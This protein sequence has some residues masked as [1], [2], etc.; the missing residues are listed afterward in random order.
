MVGSDGEEWTKVSVISEERLKFEIAKAEWEA[1]ESSSSESDGEDENPAETTRSDRRISAREDDLN[2][3][4]LVRFADALQRAAKA[5]RTR[6]KHPQVRIVLPRV[7]LNP[8]VELHSLLARIRSTGAVVVL[9]PQ[10]V[11]ST[12]LNKD[13][14][15]KLLPAP[16]PPLT[17]TLNLDCSILLA[18]AS[19]LSHAANHPILPEYKVFIKQQ[20][21]FETKEPS[22]P[23][24]LW[25]AM[26]GRNLICT[27]EAANT[28]KEIVDALGTST[29]RKRT[30]LMLADH[31]IEHDEQKQKNLRAA[32]AKV[33]DFPVP[34][35][36]RLPIYVVDV[37]VSDSDIQAAISAGGLPP[38]AQ[39]IAENLT[40]INKSVFMHGWMQ[41]I[42]TV[43][44]NRGVAR[45][46]EN[47][48]E[49]DDQGAIGPEIWVREPAR[50]LL[51]KEKERRK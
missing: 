36:W 3:I 32:F 38:V 29:E 1:G 16:H 6:Y 10:P 42:S 19:D 12:D 23:S 8:P 45:Q 50:S 46:I 27:Q 43:T 5:N 35:E 47:A 22:L 2:R 18:L 13:I 20:I 49:K 24:V 25:P 21:E 33:S 44:S 31:G 17:D 26:A 14:F 40:G 51:G 30:E 9:G 11:L 39:Q 41:Q 28:M 4:E 15:P 48:I 37:A 34:D 7:S